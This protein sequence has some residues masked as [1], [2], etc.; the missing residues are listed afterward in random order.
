MPGDVSGLRVPR[1]LTG[2]CEVCVTGELQVL[3]EAT[4]AERRA[5][6][7]VGPPRGMLLLLPRVHRVGGRAVA[8]AVAASPLLVAPLSCRA[9]ALQFGTWAHIGLN[10]SPGNHPSPFAHIPLRIHQHSC[11][12]DLSAM[13]G[14]LPLPTTLAAPGVRQCVSAWDHG[15]RFP[16]FLLPPSPRPCSIRPPYPVSLL[17][18]LP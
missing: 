3:N 18:H 4:R 16:A 5:R 9:E 12:L 1:L 15:V 7:P 14:V 10:R 8:D 6:C 11:G 17:K 13:S 2:T